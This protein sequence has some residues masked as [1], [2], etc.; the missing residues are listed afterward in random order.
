[1]KFL[2]VLTARASFSRIFS[3]IKCLNSRQ[4][5][6]IEIEI[7]LTGSALVEKF[8][9]GPP[10]INAFK[11]LNI[12]VHV[13]PVASVYENISPQLIF[14]EISKILDDLI[15]QVS[16]H[17]VM[18]VGD[19]FETLG[20]S[21]VCSIQNIP[22]VHALAGE[23]SGNVDDKIRFANTFLSDY[24][25]APSKSAFEKCKAIGIQENKLFFTGCSSVLDLYD[26]SLIDYNDVVKSI[27]NRTILKNFEG[28]FNF[29]DEDFCVLALYPET[30]NSHGYFA[31]VLSALNEINMGVYVVAPNADQGTEEF[32]N[33]LSDFCDDRNKSKRLLV[34]DVPPI[35]FYQLLNA[36]KCVVGNSSL[37]VRES[38]VLGVPAVN[39][40]TRQS[41]RDIGHNVVTCEFSHSQIVDALRICLK[42][43]RYE[44][45]A[46]Y[47]DLSNG[48]RFCN[49]MASIFNDI[50]YSR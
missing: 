45:S 38:S 36:A 20:I 39:V 42:S 2:V 6:D 22:L 14:F 50:R 31:E 15:S 33:G 9:G 32:F 8:G 3:F 28:Q 48:D 47:G 35:Y 27:E 11:G 46:E 7:L 18:V 43:P 49:A 21:S 41:G 13:A 44:Q 12:P 37:V 25:L 30:R 40:G 4:K 10:L 16:P 34:E 17:L 19:R 29:F 26:S 23:V 5:N 24:V 1:M